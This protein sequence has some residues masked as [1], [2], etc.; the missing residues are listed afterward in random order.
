MGAIFSFMEILNDANMLLSE[1]LIGCA[2]LSHEYLKL[3][4]FDT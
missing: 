2:L 1:I 4:R 3:I